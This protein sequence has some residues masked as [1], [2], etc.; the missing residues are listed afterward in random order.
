MDAS[1]IVNEKDDNRGYIG[2]PH[3]NVGPHVQQKCHR[4]GAGRKPQS[5]YSYVQYV[6]RHIVNILLSRL[7]RS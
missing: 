2:V 7:L 6:R 3:Q 5:D 1:P 4:H